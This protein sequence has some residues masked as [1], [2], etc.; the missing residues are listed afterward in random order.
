MASGAARGAKR[1][2]NKGGCP[3]LSGARPL[4]DRSLAKVMDIEELVNAAK[5]LRD[6]DEAGACAYYGAR[7]AAHWADLVVRA[8]LLDPCLVVA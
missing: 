5:G 8:L 7:E 4:A 1:K 3:F 2:A 6:G